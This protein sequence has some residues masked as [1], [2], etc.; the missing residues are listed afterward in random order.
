MMNNKTKTLYIL[1]LF[2]VLF[3]VSSTQIKVV[4]ADYHA[5]IVEEISYT[6]GG[7]NE[8]DTILLAHPL[9]IHVDDLL[10]LIVCSDNGDAGEFFNAVTNFTKLGESGDQ[11]CDSHIA[12]YYKVADGTEI[13]VNVTSTTT[14]NMLG[15][16]LRI[17]GVDTADIIEK[18]S[19]AVSTAAGINPQYIPSITTTE[20]NCLVIY[21]IALDGGDCFPTSVLS[22][23]IELADRV[24]TG[25]PLTTYVCGSFGY[26]NLDNAGPSSDCLV[27]TEETDGASYFQFAVNGNIE[28]TTTIATSIFYDVFLS[29]ELWGYF[30]P[31]ALVVIGYVITKKERPLGIFMIIVNALVL[32]YYLTLVSATPEYWWHIIIVM[33]GGI[34]CAFQYLSR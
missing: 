1:V 15:W 13:E 6:D 11:L 33:F 26:Q 8:I 28:I 4:S 14:A 20:D 23:F 17:H 16:Y 32:W 10:V 18:E 7:A 24:N 30:G 21:G 2:A 12:V 29:L 25:A 27:Y 19:F 9:N 31:L 5:P 34:L 22:P 3:T